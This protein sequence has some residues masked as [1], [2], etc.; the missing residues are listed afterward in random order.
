MHSVQFMDDS[1]YRKM[2]DPVVLVVHFD[3]DD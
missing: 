2:A 3:W 1:H